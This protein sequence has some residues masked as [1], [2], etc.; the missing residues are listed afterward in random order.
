MFSLSKENIDTNRGKNMFI[1]A[2]NEL[3][4][5]LSNKELPEMHF[6]YF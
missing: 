2:Y 3:K 6:C 5:Y 4:Q 1:N